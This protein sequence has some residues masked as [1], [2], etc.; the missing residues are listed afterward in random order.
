MSD[1]QA[2]T[3]IIIAVG[4]AADLGSRVVLAVLS[5]FIQVKARY[6]YLAG[7]VGTIA[8]RFG[9]YFI[10]FCS[11]VFSVNKFLFRLF[12]HFKF[13]KQYFSRYT[14]LSMWQF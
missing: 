13:R 2:D 14:I 3:A 1:L 12:R 6:V 10:S 7:A 4:A 11:A 9:N 5:M 8:A